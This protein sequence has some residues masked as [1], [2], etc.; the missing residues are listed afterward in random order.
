MEPAQAWAACGTCLAC[1][2][3]LVLVRWPGSTLP[4]GR[5]SVR[6]VWA[7]Q[8]SQ[9]FVKH[10]L[11]YERLHANFCNG[12]DWDGAAAVRTADAC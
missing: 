11:G 5:G 4:V 2:C 8:V 10:R 3:A 1:H 7:A 9:W 12:Y 6:P